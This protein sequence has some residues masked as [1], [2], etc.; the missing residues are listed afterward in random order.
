MQTSTPL[1]A[2]VAPPEVTESPI[3]DFECVSENSDIL[4]DPGIESDIPHEERYVAVTN[5]NTVT[6]YVFKV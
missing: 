2:R 5:V 3:I 4:V 6:V 1:R